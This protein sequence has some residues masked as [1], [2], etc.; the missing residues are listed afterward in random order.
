M[1]IKFFF[2]QTY[3]T[4]S[5]TVVLSILIIFQNKNGPLKF[6]GLITEKERVKEKFTL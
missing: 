5:K 2:Y 1:A 4:L 6:K 3:V